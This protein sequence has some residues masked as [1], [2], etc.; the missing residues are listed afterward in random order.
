VPQTQEIEIPHTQ[1][2]TTAFMDTTP[3]DMNVID[4]MRDPTYVT[5]AM[6]MGALGD[7]LSRPVLIHEITWT[8]GSTL[9]S[10][11]LNVWYEFLNNAAIKR[12]IDNYAFGSMKL[13]LKIMVN[14]TPFLYGAACFSYEPRPPFGYTL[15]V[16]TADDLVKTE[17]STAPHIMVLPQHN[18]GG[19]I[20]CPF[21]YEKDF[22]EL[23]SRSEVENMG[24]L[25]W[26]EFVP[27][28][29]ANGSSGQA[30]TIQVYAWAEDVI[31]S[32]P[33]FEVAL[34]SGWGSSVVKGI[35]DQAGSI[36]SGLSNVKYSEF[37]KKPVSTA[38][39]V[40]SAIAR[41]LS[42]VPVIG[43]FAK[44]TDIG[45]KAVGSIGAL[46]GFTNPPNINN[47][48]TIR[49]MPYFGL[50]SASISV[51][52]ET[53]TADPKAELC[54]DPRT[55]GL[56]SED[57][58]TIQYIAGKEAYIGSI[59]WNTSDPVG[60]NLFNFPVN[61]CTYNVKVNPISGWEYAMTPHCLLAN[62]FEYWR[63][64]IILRF[65]VIASQYHCGRMRIAWD[66]KSN[67]NITTATTSTSFNRIVD[68]STENDV[69]IRIPYHQATHFLRVPPVTPAP[70]LF[71]PGRS[72]IYSY[73]PEF[74]NGT[75]HGYVLN[76]LS[77][78]ET[79]ANIKVLIFA[80]C[81]ENIEFAVPSVQLNSTYSWFQPQSGESQLESISSQA[82]VNPNQ[83]HYNVFFGE[84][85]RSIRT[86]MRRSY[87]DQPLI[88]S[89]NPLGT[90]KYAFVIYNT[91]K[92]PTPNGYDPFSPY[93]GLNQSTL[94]NARCSWTINSP[95]NMLVPMYKGMRGSMMW[96]Y[97]VFG[98]ELSSHRLTGEI[99]RVNN[100]PPNTAGVLAITDT[101][102]L[103]S[104]SN[105]TNV[106]R[107]E[108][109]AN[110]LT[111]TDDRNATV[112]IGPNYLEGKSVIFPF[113]SQQRFTSTSP[114]TWISN[115]VV[116]EFPR[117][118]CI[119]LMFRSQP[120]YS[121]PVMLKEL[122]TRRYYSVGPD[123]SCFFLLCVPRLYRY[124]NLPGNRT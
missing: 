4:S 65:K 8:E 86:L 110:T 15:P 59:D 62:Q 55:V 31:L 25:K 94:G 68:I 80:R 36:Y 42:K 12:K 119:K 79:T 64:D 115:V 7:F 121:T 63:G 87:P 102:A 108:F 100:D 40:V 106:V 92:Y 27:L 58:M 96:H 11:S 49:N 123:F 9:A 70:Y 95:F 111:N 122:I 60:A 10:G 114:T 6:D 47:Q 67:L 5:D 43:L 98:D 52:V 66:P 38:S 120:R 13:H 3:Q 113:L 30:I 14:S 35:A 74:M 44:A 17:Y 26:I 93:F 51:P 84:V 104:S 82:V 91:T 107:Q 75:I 116:D 76:A 61:P 33:T 53:L 89:F 16:V 37:G 18:T 77:A 109:R 99:R 90:D 83:N 56:S 50:S 112:L 22:L 1:Q 117:S 78:P 103:G 72:F 28:A 21:F 71:V 73:D 19:E 118:E 24:V 97:E 2:Q 41:P 81:A 29:A 105:D 69:E 88:N 20:M 46:F 34:Q 101:G 48:E 85:Y 57:E 124:A 32:G 45:A 54:V 39:S 23:T